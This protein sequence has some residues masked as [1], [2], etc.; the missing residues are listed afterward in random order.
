MANQMYKNFLSAGFKDLNIRAYKHMVDLYAHNYS[1][2]LPKKK[3]AGIL[4]IGCGMGQFL[5]FLGQRGYEQILGVD[6]SEE[7]IEFCQEK[8]IKKVR[9]INDL[10]EFL[11]SCPMFDLIVLNDVIE[12]FPKSE[13]IEILQKVHEKLNAGG[14]V[15]IKTGNMASMAGLKIRYNDF[16]HESGFT[17]YSLTQVLKISKFRDIMIYPFNF[18]KNRPTRIIRW[19][20]QKVFHGIW[21]AIYFFEFTG[22]PRIVDELIV[23]V[24]RK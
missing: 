3:Q 11:S 13:I 6:V 24:G 15:I 4:D 9:L 19:L 20:I 16:T 5:E 18:P 1:G 23:A 14:K 17:D 8:G 22:V 10:Q 21:K 12:H 2:F 7:A